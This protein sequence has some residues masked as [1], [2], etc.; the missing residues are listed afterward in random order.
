MDIKYLPYILKVAECGNIS[1]AAEQLY[2]SQPAL[3]RCI[4]KIENDIGVPIFERKRKE[5]VLTDAGKCYLE[6][7]KKMQLL[8]REMQDNILHIT[9]LIKSKI[10][11]AM[12]PERVAYMLPTVLSEF[13]KLYP[14][15]EIQ[16]IERNVN[17]CEVTVIRGEADIAVVPLPTHYSGF[18][19]DVILQETVSVVAPIGWLTPKYEI[20]APV[21]FSDIY[22]WPLI[23]LKSGARARTIFDEY[24]SQHNLNP[25]ILVETSSMDAA[26]NFV[27]SKM[28]IAI[29][30]TFYAKNVAR[31]EDVDFFLFPQEYNRWELGAIYREDKEL[32]ILEQA[33]IRVFHVHFGN[34]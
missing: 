2:I 23:I 30:P 11:L 17:T 9:N 15:V 13:H 24:C 26:V 34:K 4:Q 16:T 14:N 1:K 21:D 3:S 6:S 32:S 7:A 25:T 27:R 10:V 5:V 22:K 20:G 28:G 12:S 29:I 31:R 33:L 19:Y 8:E 18:C